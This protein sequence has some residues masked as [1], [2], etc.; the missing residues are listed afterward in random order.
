MRRQ[1]FADQKQSVVTE[2]HVIQTAVSI[3]SS[4]SVF[5]FV[6]LLS[7]LWHDLNSLSDLYSFTCSYKTQSICKLF[8]YFSY[9]SQNSNLFV[10]FIIL[11]SRMLLLWR[12]SI[13]PWWRICN[14]IVARHSQPSITVLVDQHLLSSTV[15]ELKRFLTS[16]LPLF[17]LQQTETSRET[18][19]GWPPRACQELSTSSLPARFVF[20]SFTVILNEI[21]LCTS[22]CPSESRMHHDKME[23]F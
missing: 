16:R 18:R 9:P 21:K 4:V 10:L 6:C 17:L 13:T 19:L 11:P 3:S 15:H 14:H 7:V 20:L 22:C 5:L 12:T 2:L 1:W 23:F 8:R